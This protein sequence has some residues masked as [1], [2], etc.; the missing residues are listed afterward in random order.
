MAGS[1]NHPE[2]SADGNQ[3]AFVHGAPDGTSELWVINAD[4]TD[5]HLVYSCASPCNEVGYPDWS[6]DGETIYFS[7]NADVPAGEEIPRTFRIGRL[8][9]SDRRRALAR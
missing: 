6:P 7:E 4:G 8:T 1:E 2:W 9:V 5:E 3:I